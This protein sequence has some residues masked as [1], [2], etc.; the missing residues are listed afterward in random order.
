MRTDDRIHWNGGE[1]RA[2]QVGVSSPEVPPSSCPVGLGGP[3]LAVLHWRASL[4]Y[5]WSATYS[6]FISLRAKAKWCY[7]T[8]FI[9]PTTVP[10]QSAFWR[11]TV[12][13]VPWRHVQR[14]WCIPAILLNPVTSLHSV[15]EVGTALKMTI[16]LLQISSDGQSLHF[17]VSERIWYVG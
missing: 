4:P 14:S 10:S 16:F 5:V 6:L 13:C 15:K 11:I 2:E 1:A 8:D 12:S 3:A 17:M 9:V 7:S